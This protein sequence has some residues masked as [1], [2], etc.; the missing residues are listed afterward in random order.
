MARKNHK[1]RVRRGIKSG[2]APGT[3]V[4]IGERKLEQ[5][6]IDVIDF[7]EAQVSE[8]PDS[9][10]D[11]CAEL[12][13]APTVTWINIAGVHDM[14]LIEALGR[15][16]NLHPLTLEDIV[17]TTQRPKVEESPGYTFVVLKMLVYRDQPARVEQEHVSLIL[18]DNYVISLLEDEGDVFDNVR[19]RIR[20]NKGRIRRMPADFLAYS[21]MDAVV[22]HYFL[23]VEGL[24]ERIEE[25]DERILVE[26][27]RDDIR[28][29][30]R[31]KREVLKLRR[32]VWPLR[33]EIGTLEKTD[34]PLI[35]P[36]TRMFLRDLYDH[37]IQVID[38]VETNRDILA[39][40]HDTWLSSNSNRMNEIMKVLTIIATIFIPLTFIVGVYGMNFD[41]MPELR[42]H[43]GYH[44]VWVVMLAVGGGMLLW[45]RRKGW[46]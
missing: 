23:V 7:N 4:F 22:D 43:W 2:M 3:P 18:G 28:E 29:I 15:R 32:A 9:D 41:Y 21:L 42:W 20:Q 36:D 12:L 13:R 40:M 24:G 5:A 16:F 31:L 14:G 6:R 26:P 38:M 33:E 1:V 37:T 30:H 46:F 27:R 10:L 35:R 34:S 45:F 25:I 39:G 44:A 8:H 19:E 17:N 11:T